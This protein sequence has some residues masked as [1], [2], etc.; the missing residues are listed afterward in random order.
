MV[1]R[2]KNKTSP[3]KIWKVKGGNIQTDA[4]VASTYPTFLW[5][6]VACFI[7]LALG[8]FIGYMVFGR[9]SKQV[10]SIKN[11]DESVPR[12]NNIN[13]APSPPNPA[14]FPVDL[15]EQ[16]SRLAL[17]INTPT[18]GNPPE[19]QQIGILTAGNSGT[20]DPF[21]LPL[22]G[23]PVYYGSQKWE[24]YAASDKFHLWRIPIFSENRDCSL[25]L[26]CNEIYDRDT[27]TVPTYQGKQFTVTLYPKNTPRYIPP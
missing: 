5:M 17:P 7:I 4:I 26:G 23:R 8:L 11:I 2:L 13:S 18:R 6:I 9:Q 21:I 16:P 12:I 27:V 1:S 25:Q 24:Y 22:Y 20:E 3:K 10:I 14:V 15:P 19:Y